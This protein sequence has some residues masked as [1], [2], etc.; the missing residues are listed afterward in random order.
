VQVWD[1][2]K[3]EACGSVQQLFICSAVCSC[4]VVTNC[5]VSI[6]IDIFLARVY[7][8]KSVQ[9]PWVSTTANSPTVRC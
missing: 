9:L 4:A 1:Q 2:W 3:L 7:N 8:S 5:S 6:N